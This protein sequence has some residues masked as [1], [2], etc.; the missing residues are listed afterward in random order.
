MP[1]WQPADI[2]PLYD[3]GI[4]TRDGKPLSVLNKDGK[5]VQVSSL[6]YMSH[7]DPKNPIKEA[8]ELQEKSQL[9]QFGS[10]ALID[11]EFDQWPQTTQGDWSGGI[12]QRVFD[13]NG[14]R[15]QYFDGEG[16]LWPTNDWVPQIG[17]RGPVQGQPQGGSA[18]PS[19]PDSGTET[20]APGGSQAVTQAALILASLKATGLIAQ[21][22]AL[23]AFTQGSNIAVNPPFGQATVATHCLVA[24][25]T[26]QR[27]TL[28]GSANL[29]DTG[30]A[31][32]SFDFSQV[33][34]DNV[35]GTADTFTVPAGGIYVTSISCYMGGYTAAV[36]TIFAV[37]NANT[38][39]VLC[40]SS[41]FSAGQGRS[42]KTAAIAS[43]FIAA[44]T[45]I[46][47]GF[48][49][50]QNQD[51]T[52][53]VANGGSFNYS[54][55]VGWPAT[56]PGT[57]CAPAY[58]CGNPQMYLTYQQLTS[59]DITC[60]DGTWSKL[61]QQNSPDG[62]QQ[63]QIWAKPNCGAG[64]AAPTWTASQGATPMHARLS[65]WSNVAL[66]TPTDQTATATVQ[67]ASSLSATAGAIDTVAG[68]LVVM[69]GRWSISA[70]QTCGFT[71]SFNNNIVA[72]D[73]G[74]SGGSTLVQ[75]SAFAFGIVP[76]GP[77]TFASFG[78]NGTAGG[79]IEGLGMGYA[80]AY[81]D[82]QG[83]TPHW[84]ACFFSG[85]QYFDVDLGA[86]TG[87]K[88]GVLHMHIA[89]GYLWVLFSEFG[90]S[91]QLSVRMLGC[92]YGNN[93]FVQ[94]RNDLVGAVTAGTS[95][96]S[97]LIQASFVGGHLYVAVLQGDADA[98]PGAPTVNRNELFVLDYSAGVGSAPSGL[99]AAAFVFPFERGFK[100][101]DQTWQGNTLIVSVT[102]GFS[103]FIYSLVAP[104]SAINTLAVLPGVANALCCA[105]GSVIFIIGWT[106]VASGLNQM[107]LY[108]L[109]GGTLTQV[110]FTPIVPFPDSV[111][112]CVGF[113]PYAMWAISYANPG[114]PVGQ[115]AI[116]V[117]AF[118]TTANRLFR[119]LSTTSANWIGN[120]VFGHDVVGIY[121]IVPRTLAAG[122]TFQ[123]QLG[124]AVFSGEIANASETAR[125]FY[126]GV[127]P[128]T[129]VPPFTGLLQ[130]GVSITSGLIDFTAATNKLFRA[131]VSRFFKSLVV[132][133]TQPSITVSAWLGQ[134]PNQLNAVPD[135]TT[136]T[137]TPVAPI[138]TE[139][140]LFLN[141]IGRKLVYQ[142]I[143][144]GGGYNGAQGWQN[145]PKLTDI[146]IQ[147]A[148]GWVID[149]TLDLSPG[150]KVNAQ[151]VS[152]YAYQHQGFDH[153][154]AYNFLKQ[155]WR[156]RGGQVV[157][158][159]PNLDSY[160][161]LIQSEEFNSPKPFAASY[162]SDQQ[163]TYQS[164][165]TIKIRE[166]V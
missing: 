106:A 33:N 150:A 24:A 127:L 64:E 149:A 75:H 74:D 126:W 91:N 151:N 85:D 103:A 148:T 158:T 109:T 134:D 63:T 95:G 98:P 72:I 114:G 62:Y 101:I 4:S 153:V 70:A 42:L 17:L 156:Q 31:T 141:S 66:A 117:Y 160:N 146:I 138:P 11:R 18:S 118:D 36:N 43:V 53:G 157:I 47:I 137:G 78:Y 144:A 7:A 132:G 139:L 124:V 122:A 9:V 40:N 92:A 51:A 152:E 26:G 159:L 58:V 76:S 57:A 50:Q 81:L 61:L 21:I 20:A 113:G 12:G 112:S 104:F 97:G 161:A 116:S 1:L 19:A 130:M 14:V 23:G 27:S 30:A 59:A 69:V 67:N 29:G 93:T 105:I 68:D 155:L 54:T 163:T 65:E 82:N 100:L 120:D 79:F 140:G 96:F 10:S 87:N 56:Q 37:W 15:S 25:V 165:C 49:R 80:A 52:W 166:D 46:R 135:F 34:S 123:A 102:D 108:T 128:R 44:G 13:T 32:F 3:F 107:T 164:L 162:R 90:N 94:L 41:S 145:A 77:A 131:V 84:H 129:P 110:F 38:G 154:A 89:G 60:S 8:T 147:A 45:V 142:V 6:A 136:N 28:S 5:P 83:P 71:K 133:Q 2:G 143:S 86:N 55:N 119:A 22:G 125:E 88:Q 39:A 73:G 115:K 111:T 16:L 121:G 99:A 48:W 35:I